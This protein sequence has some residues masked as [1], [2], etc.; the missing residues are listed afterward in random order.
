MS[1]IFP[2]VC[3]TPTPAAPFQSPIPTSASRLTLRLAYDCEDGWSDAD[4]EGRQV[5]DV[6]G[7]EAGRPGRR[8]RQDQGA[9]RVHDAF[10]RR[11]IRGKNVCR[12]ADP[13]FHNDK[14][15]MG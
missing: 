11:E 14:N 6:H 13:L 15:G 5:R 9:V 8:K 3:K 7:D 1:P 2:D 12:L 4:D 10:V